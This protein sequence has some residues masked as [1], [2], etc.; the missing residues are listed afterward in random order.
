MSRI[1]VLESYLP[2]SLLE[3]ATTQC[4]LESSHIT[5]L[6]LHCIV[7]LIITTIHLSQPPHAARQKESKDQKYGDLN[8]AGHIN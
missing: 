2:T 6:N 8:S 5:S 1:F 3:K 4:A 7:R